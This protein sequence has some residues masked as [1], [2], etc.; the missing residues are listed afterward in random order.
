MNVNAF[1]IIQDML[2]EEL[3]DQGF[4]EPEQIDYENGKATMMATDDVAYSLAYDRKRERFELRSCTLNADGKPDNE[5]RSLSVWLFDENDGTKSD[6]E[7]IANDFLEVVRGPKRVAY[8]QK[9]KKKAK[10]EDRAVDPVFFFNRLVTTFPE[11]RDEM[12]EERIVYGQIRPATFTKEKVVPKVDDLTS[13]YA[14]SA[15]VNKLCTL[16]S[17]MYKDGDLD[18]R[19]ILTITLFNELSETAFK[20]IEKNENTSDELKKDM[21]YTRKLKGKKIKPEKKK[22]EKKVQAR[23]D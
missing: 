3:Q 9:T 14:D 12:N 2:M 11:L 5:W 16:F 22:K 19:S 15:P 18:T 20:N 13:K 21:K 4:K 6:A 1:E 7:S 23:L 8:V 17:D 10:G